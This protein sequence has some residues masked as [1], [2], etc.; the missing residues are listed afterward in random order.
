MV[1]YFKTTKKD[2]I[3]SEK[4]EKQR[5]DE[6]NCRFWSEQIFSDNVS[7]HCHLTGN[8]RDPT[9]QNVI[10]MSYR[11]KVIFYHLQSSISVNKI[12]IYFSRS[13]MIKIMIK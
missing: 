6:N 10:L 5:R 13:W 1:F 8:Y 7:D 11:N 2:I 12:I 4:Y 9:Q 3:E